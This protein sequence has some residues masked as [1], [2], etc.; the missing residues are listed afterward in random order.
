M[1]IHPVLPVPRSL[2]ST[3]IPGTSTTIS[4][5][6]NSNITVIITSYIPDIQFS[7]SLAA[8]SLVIWWRLRLLLSMSEQVTGFQTD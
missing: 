7:N 2:P 3:A 4:H 6:S 1:H 5:N 8:P